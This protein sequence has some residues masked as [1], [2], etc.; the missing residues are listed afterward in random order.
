LPAED[1][2]TVFLERYVKEVTD[3]AERIAKDPVPLKVA[4]LAKESAHSFLQNRS[5]LDTN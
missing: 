4:Q 3:L 2:R 5:E 1:V